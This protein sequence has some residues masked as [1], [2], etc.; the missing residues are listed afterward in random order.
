MIRAGLAW[1]ALGCAACGGTVIEKNGGGAGGAA[2]ALGSETGA[3]DAGSGYP[4]GPGQ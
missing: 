1:I 4:G 2:G 3:V